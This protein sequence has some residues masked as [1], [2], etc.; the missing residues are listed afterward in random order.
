MNSFTIK[1]LSEY[2]GIGIST[3]R[4]LVYEKQ[5]PYFKIGCKYFF[6]KDSIDSWIKNK[7]EENYGN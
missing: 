7:E 1:E 4:K 6:R 3:I 5:L 2:M